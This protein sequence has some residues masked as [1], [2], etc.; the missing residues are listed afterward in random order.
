M[1][2]NNLNDPNP[3][4]LIQLARLLMVEASPA[5]VGDG[6]TL[7]PTKQST[8]HTDLPLFVFCIESCFFPSLR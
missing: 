5:Q 2:Q 8:K 7:V 6:F 4:I 3:G 1:I